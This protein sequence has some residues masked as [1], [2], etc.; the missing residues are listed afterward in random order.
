MYNFYVRNVSE[1]LFVVKQSLE[2]NGVAVSTRGGD[3]LEFPGPVTTTYTHPR[4]R[5]LFYPQRDANP[6]FHFMESLWMLAGRN[7]VQFVNTFNGR[8]NQYSDDG[9]TYHGAYGYRW[10]KWFGYDQFDRV[11]ERLLSFPNDRR[12]VLTMW[13]PVKDLV[14][15]NNGKDYPCNTQI[16]FSERKDLLNMTVVNRSNDLI[17]GAYGANAVH[18]SMLQE[19]FAG[20]LELGV[21]TYTQF[22]NNLHAYVD[23]LERLKDMP[24]DYEPYLTLGEDGT[25]YNPMPIMDSFT[26]FDDELNTFFKIWDDKETYDVLDELKKVQFE[27]SIFSEVAVPML[28]CYF[29]YKRAK[30]ADFREIHTFY[31]DESKKET[32]EKEEWGLFLNRHQKEVHKEA[33]EGGRYHALESAKSIK[34]LAWRKA[35]VEWITRKLYDPIK[36]K[37]GRKSEKPK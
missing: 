6:F 32:F 24:P 3:V 13:D 20:R 17:W 21:G 37:K 26:T 7:D 30:M 10:R 29:N 8:M 33:W 19:Y 11:I 25:S 23:I 27:N 34:D 5:V 35:C 2:E 36:P 14:E 12:T 9:I 15:T 4:E 31:K 1:A 16:F 28:E 18:M 22:S